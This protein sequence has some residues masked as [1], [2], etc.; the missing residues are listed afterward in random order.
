DEVK[1]LRRQFS[2]EV[3]ALRRQLRESAVTADIVSS[4]PKM[5]RIRE[6][7]AQVSATDVLVLILGESGVGKE[8]LARFIHA[9]SGRADKQLV[10]VNCAAM[11]HALLASK[12]FG[13]DRASFTGSM[14][15]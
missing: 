3:K 10:A 4:Y 12:L 15:E 7:A 14:H 8:V 6:V 5:I 2:D 13:I 1:A 11:P 9:R